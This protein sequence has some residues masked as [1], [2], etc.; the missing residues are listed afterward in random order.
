M[1]AHVLKNAGVGDNQPVW[2]DFANGVDENGQ[3]F[4]VLVVGEEV[5]G[6]IDA[7]AAL[8][9]VGDA[10]YYVFKR[11]G[12][13]GTQGHVWRAKVNGICAVEDGGF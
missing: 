4:D 12:G 2:L 5:E 10:F 6:E 11:E 7:L 9:G 8:V 1:L 3:F 13:L